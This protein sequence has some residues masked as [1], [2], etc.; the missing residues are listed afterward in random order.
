MS[1][2][3]DV[4]QGF[5]QRYLDTV[6]SGSAD[7]VAAL[8][9]EDA[10]LEDPVGGGE[11][12]IGRQAIAGFYKAIQG[13]EIKTELLSFRAGGHE[14]AFLFAITVGGAMR[15]EPIEVMTFNGEGQITSMKAYWGPQNITQLS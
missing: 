1:F 4:L 14:A 12:H 10:T 2:E 8:Y 6:V 5:V 13:G 7:D 11:V 9:A 15:I 3:P